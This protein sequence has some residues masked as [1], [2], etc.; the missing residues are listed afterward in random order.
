MYLPG[1]PRSSNGCREFEHHF[2]K[3]PQGIWLP[4]CGYVEGV[5]ALL[6]RS[7]LRYFFTDT[8]GILFST[9]RPTYGVYGRFAVP[10][11]MFM[12]AGRDTESSKQVWSSLEGY[13]GDYIYREFYRD[14]GFIST[15]ITSSRTC[16]QRESVTRPAS[17][18]TKSPDEPIT[19][20]LTTP[21]LL[22]AGQG[23]TQRISCSTAKSRPN[24]SAAR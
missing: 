5:D 8:H 14:I 7:G 22:E 16:T 3:R 21:K 6:A 2:G 10:I 1:M 17:S 24:G 11:T 4:E 18:I 9:P 23:T 15:S 20:S 13:P 19:S 12:G